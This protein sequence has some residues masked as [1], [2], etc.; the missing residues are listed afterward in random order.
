MHA[1]VACALGMFPSYRTSTPPTLCDISHGRIHTRMFLCGEEY[2]S[3]VK[4][5]TCNTPPP[6]RIPAC[7]MLSELGNTADLTIHNTHTT[8]A[9]VEH[10]QSTN[11]KTLAELQHMHS[12]ATQHTIDQD[13][14]QLRLW[15]PTLSVMMACRPASVSRTGT[16]P[17]R[18]AGLCQSHLN[19][20][21]TS[22]LFQNRDIN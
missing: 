9:D 5:S 7:S 11:I 18:R 1:H 4:V 17:N 15:D 6:P 8:C 10:Q 3:G 16:E 21:A 12:T 20:T 13:Q 22:S 14:N 19:S 2:R